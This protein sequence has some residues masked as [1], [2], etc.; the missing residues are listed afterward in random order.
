MLV[1]EKINRYSRKVRQVKVY[2]F[3]TLIMNTMQN[4]GIIN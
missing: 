4:P 1:S 2:Y 3:K